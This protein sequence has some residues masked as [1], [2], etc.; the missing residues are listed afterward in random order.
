MVLSLA[1][2]LL[3]RMLPPAMSPQSGALLITPTVW[4]VGHSTRSPDE[5]LK[6]LI[7]YDIELVTDVRRFPGSRR[8]P[9]FA[10]ETLASDLPTA[11]IAYRWLP[12]L[13]GRRRPDPH[14][15]NVGWRHPAFRAYA[16]HLESEEFAAGLFELMMLA[17]GLRTV[18]MCAEALWWR[19][20]RRLIADVLTSLGFPV[21][22]IRGSGGS[23]AHDLPASADRERAP[24]IRLNCVSAWFIVPSRQ[25]RPAC[26]S[27]GIAETRVGSALHTARSD[28]RFHHHPRADARRLRHPFW[29]RLYLRGHYE[30]HHPTAALARSRPTSPRYFTP[31]DF[32]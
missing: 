13:G 27:G 22:H 19:C 5:F 2:V 6:L 31:N 7:A 32:T 17:H 21:V 9:H 15:L 24:A 18:I 28:Q 1:R 25:S 11:G 8:L 20:H 14:S 29:S 10:S 30:V 12:S 4:T 3:Q 26:R 23:E 16:D